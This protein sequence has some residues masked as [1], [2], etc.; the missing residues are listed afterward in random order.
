MGTLHVKPESR[1]EYDISRTILER[2]MKRFLAVYIGTEE[3]MHA[4]GWS[5]LSETERQQR[6]KTGLQAWKKWV[7]DNQDAILEVGAPLGK[8]LQTSKRGV[9]A[10]R[11]NL[12][13]FTVVQ[14]PSQE[15]AAKLF[16][17]HPHFTVFPGDSIE[18]MECLP[19]P[20]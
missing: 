18:I 15:A 16:E 1:P 5:A 9:E 4:S 20:E 8:T 10:T 7:E 12:T 2:T 13:G 14:A 11:N 19:L 3:S 17:N 6:A